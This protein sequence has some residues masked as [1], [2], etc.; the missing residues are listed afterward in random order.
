M[1]HLAMLCSAKILSAQID[2]V[3]IGGKLIKI[4]PMLMLLYEDT[5]KVS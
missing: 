1:I 5:L 2:I 3:D 4:I